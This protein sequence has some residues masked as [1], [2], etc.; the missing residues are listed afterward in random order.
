MEALTKRELDTVNALRKL[1]LAV[2]RAEDND[3]SEASRKKLS[4][5]A[6]AAAI[7][8]VCYPP[9][10]KRVGDIQSGIDRTTSGAIGQP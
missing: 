1:I 4:K 5:S 7:A 3:Y 6:E 9:S 8:S 2:E 10:M